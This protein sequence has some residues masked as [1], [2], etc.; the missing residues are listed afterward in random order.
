[1]TGGFPLLGDTGVSCQQEEKR[2]IKKNLSEPFLFLHCLWMLSV[3]GAA[4]PPRCLQRVG[5]TGVSQTTP[6]G[7]CQGPVGAAHPL[8]GTDGI[9]YYFFSNPCQQWLLSA[10]VN[11]C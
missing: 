9:F 7:A 2:C 3:H 10:P 1:M 6:F 11:R 5:S 8:P 4:S